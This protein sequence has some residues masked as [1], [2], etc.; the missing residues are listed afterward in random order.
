M[1]RLVSTNMSQ[2]I[3]SLV[4]IHNSLPFDTMYAMYLRKRR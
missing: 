2:A 4:I 3:P 1:L